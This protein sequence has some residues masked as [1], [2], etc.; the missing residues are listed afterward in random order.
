MN[1]KNYKTEQKYKITTERHID[2][3]YTLRVCWCCACSMVY[4]RV[5]VE[6]R[7]IS[8]VTDEFHAVLI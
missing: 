2:M 4:L 5:N 3:C 6:F 8:F 7:L 1:Q